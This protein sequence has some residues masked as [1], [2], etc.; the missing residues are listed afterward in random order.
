MRVRAQSVGLHAAQQSVAKPCGC[1]KQPHLGPPHLVLSLDVGGVL[2]QPVG[3][4][5]GVF[6][7]VERLASLRLPQP[8]GHRKRAGAAV[9][10]RRYE[11]L[12]V[13]DPHKQ[14]TR[15]AHVKS[16]RSIMAG[17]C[18]VWTSAECERQQGTNFSRV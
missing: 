4:G 12:R 8:H 10:N 2:R 13:C 5:V 14:F 9:R 6:K 7:L 17:N 3:V 16:R 18:R 11:H 15:T 1:L